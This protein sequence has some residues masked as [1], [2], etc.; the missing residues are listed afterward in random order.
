[1]QLIF[2]LESNQSAKT[3]WYYIK[4]FIDNNYLLDNVKLSPIFMAGKSKYDLQES[5]ICKL[6]NGYSNVKTNINSNIKSIVIICYDIDIL[7]DQQNKNLEE[8]AARNEYETIW[9]YPEIENVF[10]NKHI[11]SSEKVNYAKKFTY[12]YQTNRIHLNNLKLN[13][14]Q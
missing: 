10:W 5:K 8:Y 3:D 14:M 4:S 9:F 6:K 13:K 7:N 12:Y 11:E 1:M 2:L